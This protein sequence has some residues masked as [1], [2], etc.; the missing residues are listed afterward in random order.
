MQASTIR[1]QHRPQI[2]LITTMLTNGSG[3]GLDKVVDIAG[4]HP[5]LTKNAYANP[6]SSTSLWPL[7]AFGAFRYGN[8][9]IEVNKVH[10]RRHH[11]PNKGGAGAGAWDNK[12]SNSALK[13]ADFTGLGYKR[14]VRKSPVLGG[15]PGY[16]NDAVKNEVGHLAGGERVVISEMMLAQGPAGP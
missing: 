1:T 16:P 10:Q 13:D 6:V 4:Y 11:K 5:N 3:G 7:T 14:W 15:T 8:N 9:K 2:L 12:D